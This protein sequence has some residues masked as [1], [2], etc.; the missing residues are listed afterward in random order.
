MGSTI[1]QSYLKQT[2]FDRLTESEFA[3]IKRDQQT[4]YCSSKRIIR[5]LNDPSM[6]NIST[7]NLTTQSR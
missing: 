7:C 4:M 3:E 5:P 1:V 6:E 2:A